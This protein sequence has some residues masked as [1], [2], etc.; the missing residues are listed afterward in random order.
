VASIEHEEDALNCFVAESV[1]LTGAPTGVLAGRTFVAK[2]LF[3]LAGH[4]ASFGHARW[5]ETHF[6]DKSTAPVIEKLLGAGA[7]MV[8]LVKL[9]QLAYSLVGNTGE[10]EPP[11]NSAHPDRFTGGSSSGAAAAVAGGVC[12]F[13]LGTDTAGSIRVPAASCGLYSIRPSRG[14]INVSGVLPLAPSFDVVG[15]LA[16][17]PS[18]LAV[19]FEAIA[20]K[21][22]SGGPVPLE[23]V[24]VPCDDLDAAELGA[25]DAVIGVV[26]MLASK[27]GVTV[28]QV[29]LAPLVNRRVA[30]LLARVQAR[31]VWTS[32]GI[33]VSENRSI[34]SPDVTERLERAELLARSPTN[35]Q[36]SDH[37]MLVDYRRAFQ[38]LVAPGTAIALPVIPGLPPL[39]DATPGELS[40]FRAG[41]FRWMAPASLTGAPQIVVPFA[42]G[43]SDL[44]YG[45]GL[46]AAPGQDRALLGALGSA[47]SR[48]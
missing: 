15:L 27:L 1:G 18:L 46:L 2:D 25:W 22:R 47:S 41:A 32:H 26:S 10:G 4:T 14:M 11:L 5:R 39:R 33:W 37:R 48:P 40:E 13:G 9:D 8:G 24:L 23:R 30:D 34:F 44:P 43:A 7:E 19:A 12:D 16:R 42:S 45:V 36:A 6:A 31:E 38:D 28:E 3:S 20:A 17:E 29:P 35:E 21:K